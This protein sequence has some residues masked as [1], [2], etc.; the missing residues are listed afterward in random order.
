MMRTYR[1]VA[2]ERHTR[3][4]PQAINR[5]ASIHIVFEKELALKFNSMYTLSITRPSQSSRSIDP[6]DDL[7]QFSNA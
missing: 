5:L 3:F 4:A 1:A 6:K 7:F 2:S